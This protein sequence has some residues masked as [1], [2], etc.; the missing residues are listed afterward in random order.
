MPTF[1]GSSTF[2]TFNSLTSYYRRSTAWRR[3]KWMGEVSS[4]R[5]YCCAVSLPVAF[6]PDHSTPHHASR[7]TPSRG[8]GR[9]G[10]VGDFSQG[11]Q[12]FRISIP[13]NKS[14]FSGP[15]AISIVD[16]PGSQYPQSPSYVTGK[17]TRGNRELV[18]A[19]V[20]VRQTHS[21]PSSGSFL[22][23][24]FFALLPPR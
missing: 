5:S 11:I 22:L 24:S 23:R 13:A 7:T 12:F 10:Y 21:T 3:P 19:R 17:A 14:R 9:V 16:S 20:E 2:S 1:S 6:P 15:P 8:R 4:T 18:F